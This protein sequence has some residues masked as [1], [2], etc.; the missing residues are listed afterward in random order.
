MSTFGIEFEMAALPDGWSGDYKQYAELIRQALT[1]NVTGDFLGGVVGGTPPVDDDEHPPFFNT[2]DFDIQFWDS[3]NARYRIVG[4]PPI[5]SIFPILSV[6]PAPPK[7]YLFLDGVLLLQTDWP[8]LF[9]VIGIHF[10]LVDPP[11]FDDNPATHFRLPDLRGRLIVNAGSGIHNRET[12][13][14]AVLRNRLLGK[15]FNRTYDDNVETHTNA[16][17]E[18]AKFSN[19]VLIIPSGNHMI[20]NL[21]P[22]LALNY[23]MRAK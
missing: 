9:N 4:G 13:S 18:R 1:G 2:T 3:V 21:P 17:D 15:F 8:D 19:T 12:G 10:N 23:I 11:L 16:P 5:G 7:N 22:S 20:D 6:A 14:S